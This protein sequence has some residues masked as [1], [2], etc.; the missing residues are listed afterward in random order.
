MCQIG[1][2]SP[3]GKGQCLG[4]VKCIDNLRCSG[5]CSDA[6]KGSFNRQQS[7]AAEGIIQYDRQ[8]QIVF[9]KFYGAGDAAYRPRRG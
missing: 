8:V 1:C 2:K 5:R 3:K 9:G 4:I 6:A 7:H